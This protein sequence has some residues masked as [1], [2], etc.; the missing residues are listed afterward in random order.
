MK[1]KKIVILLLLILLVVAIGAGAAYYFILRPAA[2]AAAAEKP[3]E[4]YE[5]AI[6][7]S[8]VTNVKDSNKLLKT[9]IVLVVD[10][11]DLDDFLDENQYTIRDTILFIL[12]GLTED[13]I[14]NDDIQ[15][16]LRQSIPEA[17]NEALEIDSIVSIYFSDFVM[18]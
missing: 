7:D 3:A 2:A 15:D 4:L 18:Q 11:K 13:D 8:F 12:R 10:E 1:K 14:K 9:T 5:Y 17:L 6:S 16:T